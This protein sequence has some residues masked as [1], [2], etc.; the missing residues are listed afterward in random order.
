MSPF[1]LSLMVLS[2]ADS[3][4][5]APRPCLPGETGVVVLT[6]A[7]TLHLCHEGRET[8]SYPVSL[9]SGGVGKQ[10]E[11][12]GKTPIGAYVLAA[13]RASSSYRT[14]VHV[15]Y[16][17]QAQQKAGFTGTAIG[18]HGPPRGWTGGSRAFTAV[19]WTAGCIAVGS[20]A[21]IDAIAG[22]IRRHHIRG[23]RIQ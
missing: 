8:A 4:V 22:W 7:R 20:D 12:D 23:V 2:L 21:E 1:L 5:A 3:S 14:F 17:T 9:G 6:A 19:D 16:P 13:P 15:G 11:G 18:I 10:R